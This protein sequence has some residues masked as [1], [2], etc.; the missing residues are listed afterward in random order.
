MKDKKTMILNYL[1]KINLAST[2]KIADKIKANQLDAEKYL[3]ELMQEDKI[4]VTCS[5]DK[6]LKW[7]SLK[8]DNKFKPLPKGQTM[9]NVRE[10]LK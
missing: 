4:Q 7:W 8:S 1:N 2:R 6:N 10:K 9:E 5:P 3:V